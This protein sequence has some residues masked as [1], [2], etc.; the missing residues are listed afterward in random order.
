VTGWVMVMVKAT[1][2]DLATATGLV[3]GWVMAMDW[4]TAMEMAMLVV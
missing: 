2:M 1:G 4:A 3:M